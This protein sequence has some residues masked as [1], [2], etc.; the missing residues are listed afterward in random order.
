MEIKGVSVTFREIA[1]AAT[2]K[3]GSDADRGS[4]SRSA[5]ISQT[6]SELRMQYDD[7][8]GRIIARIVDPESHEVV[9]QI[10]AEEVVDFLRKFRRLVGGLVDRTV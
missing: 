1:A 2:V 5:S 10:P 9:R 3:K 7:Q 6:T 8:I 4:G